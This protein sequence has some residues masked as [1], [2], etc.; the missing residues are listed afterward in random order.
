MYKPSFTLRARDRLHR[1][2]FRGLDI[3]GIFEVGIGFC[4][5]AD[6]CRRHNIN[7]TGMDAS[8]KLLSQA[9]KSGFTVYEG[10]APILPEVT[11][12][13]NTV[14][15]AHLIEHLKNYEEALNFLENCKKQ[16]KEKQGRY[17]ILL[18][19]DIE[20]IGNFFWQDYTHAFVT[21]KKRI[22]DMLFD[23]GFKLVKSGRYTACFFAASGLISLVGKVFPYFILPPKVAMF[24][25]LS[26]QQHG[27]A[28]AEI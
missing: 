23:T 21:T 26:F 25:R 13:F 5:L 8:P 3:Q 2:L 16:I 24:A 28:V 6:Y 11:E 14:F 4:E 17:L 9:R 27:Y 18:F 15:S 10:H 12:S 19:P 1:I 7:W 22:E 20:K